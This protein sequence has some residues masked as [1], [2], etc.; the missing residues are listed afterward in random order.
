M[1]ARSILLSLLLQVV[2]ILVSGHAEHESVMACHAGWD[3]TGVPREHVDEGVSIHSTYS[4]SRYG[5]CAG[6]CSCVTFYLA[7]TFASHS[8]ICTS[9]Q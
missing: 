5:L 1:M 8:K 2:L 7:F 9:T 3:K 6:F 4:S